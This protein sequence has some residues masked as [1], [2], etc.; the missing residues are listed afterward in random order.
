MLIV[1]IIIFEVCQRKYLTPTK[2][3]STIPPVC[4]EKDFTGGIKFLNHT[5]G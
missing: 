5:D 2:S 4:K 1:S 3:C